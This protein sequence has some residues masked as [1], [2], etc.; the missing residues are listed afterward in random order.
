MVLAHEVGWPMTAEAAIAA[1]VI[2]TWTAFAV[3][4]VLVQRRLKS[5]LPAGP[6]TWE[7]VKWL[8]IALPLLAISF[9]E[10]VLQTA[11]ILIVSRFM[12]S[13]DVAVY[14][15]AAKTMSLVMFVH[16]AVGSAVA[17]RFSML[18]AR[19]DREALVGFVRDAVRW[20]FWPS[21]AVAASLLALGLP[22]LW[23][24]GP[25]F[26]AGY[27]LMAILAVGFLGRAAMGPSEFL[28][29][30]LGEQRTCALIACTAAATSVVLNLLLVPRA[31]LMGAAVASATA[32]M[33]GAMLNTIAAR[34]RL[35]LEIAIWARAQK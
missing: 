12:P 16:Y 2:A 13:A 7:P 5:V 24:F 28:L 8:G 18:N 27:P 9:S 22:L 34:R 15:A 30:M 10:L 19:G 1:A 32:M 11:D 29:N 35:G 14:F 23:L 4:W 3:Q 21:L 17:N 31:G 25:E 20:T 6:S 33:L 26:T